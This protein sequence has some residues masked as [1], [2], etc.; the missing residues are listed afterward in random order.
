MGKLIST[1]GSGS[2]NTRA[3][4]EIPFV[5]GDV[6]EDCDPAVGLIARFGEELDSR[7]DHA[8][9][10]GVEVVNLEEEADAAG[11]LVADGC[12]LLRTVGLGEQYAGLPAPGTD[13]HPSLRSPI[14]G[15]RRRIFDELEVERF[16]EEGD[17]RV[18][19][20]D[21][22][23]SELQGR[24][25]L[26]MPPLGTTSDLTSEIVG[27]VYEKSWIRLPHV[28]SMMAMVRG[29]AGVGAWITRTP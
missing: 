2:T 26:S 11:E 21:D 19:V 17:G 24:H 18:V 8:S 14:V 25:R 1:A 23:R 10:C 4:Q 28:S 29:P 15:L 20:L 5:A 3:G 7:L 27:D 6:E 13:N 12:A 22:D 16:D 9:V